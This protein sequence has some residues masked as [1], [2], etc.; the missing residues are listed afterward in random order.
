M[1]NQ[2]LIP[3]ALHGIIEYLAAVA[4]IAAPFVLDFDSGA[5]TAVSIV[6]GVGMLVIEAATEA[7][8]TLAKVIPVGIHAVLDFVVG[9][10]LIA[11]PFLFGF[12]DESTPTALFIALG[13]LGL[14]VPIG[15]RFLPPRAPQHAGG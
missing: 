4:F 13:V 8:A 10:V 3:R 2:G 15:T 9:A 5:A 14:L 1:L 12:S 6:V 7:P 11:S